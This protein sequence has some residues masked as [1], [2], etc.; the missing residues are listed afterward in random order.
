[1]P[2]LFHPGW[3]TAVGG[4]IS[5]CGQK[6]KKKQ[7]KY[8]WTSLLTSTTQT[9]LAD[10]LLLLLLNLPGTKTTL[11]L[12]VRPDWRA[13]KSWLRR[14][15]AI[16]FSVVDMHPMINAIKTSL[17]DKLACPLEM[18]WMTASWL[19][20]FHFIMGKKLAPIISIYVPPITNPYKTKYKFYKDFEYVIFAVPAADKL[21]ILG[22]FNARVGHN[23]A[24]WEGV[25]GKQE[26]R[27][28]HSNG[29]LLLQTCV[30]HNLLITN[31]IFYLPIHNKK[32]WMHPCSKH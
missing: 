25:L 32:S 13:R 31:T 28:C 9:D 24:S 18:G 22:D 4:D 17:I 6:K 29:L 2:A 11:P 12:S 10:V 5:Q 15:Q 19:W 30:K 20:D 23:S 26:T 27:K 16:L 1:M 8:F 3:L 14:V 7:K 21:I